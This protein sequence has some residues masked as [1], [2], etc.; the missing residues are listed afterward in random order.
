M[1][2]SIKNAALSLII[3]QI[4]L[5]LFYFMMPYSVKLMD[6]YF[7]YETIFTVASNALRI[8][9]GV[10]FAY[11]CWNENYQIVFYGIVGL[12]LIALYSY[13]YRYN[14]A[15]RIS[16]ASTFFTINF[17]LIVIAAH[18]LTIIFSNAWSNKWLRI[19]TILLLS[20][21]I[22]M[23]LMGVFQLS[24]V[25]NLLMIAIVFTPAPFIFLILNQDNQKETEDRDILDR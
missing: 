24:M 17:N 8:T 6:I 14:N 15:F 23:V 13:L 18:G 1:N 16:E 21:N 10:L 3:L 19:Y 7:S 2:S 22:L 25:H 11:Y 12:F 20:T 5:G 9:L 4:G